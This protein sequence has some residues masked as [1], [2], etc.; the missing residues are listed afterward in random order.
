V[1][2]PPS[3]A[4]QRLDAAGRDKVAHAAAAIATS[5]LAEHP[6][7]VLRDALSELFDGGLGVAYT[8]HEGVVDR[9]V[10]PAHESVVRGIVHRHACWTWDAPDRMANRAVATG[11]LYGHD[12]ERIARFREALGKGIPGTAYQARVAVY[13]GARMTGW[14]GVLRGHHPGEFSRDDLLVLQALLPFMRPR[15]A[16]LR[17]FHRAP[18][19]DACVTAVLDALPQRAR[20]IDAAGRR[21]YANGLDAVAPDAPATHAIPLLL[22]DRPY[23]VD[24]RPAAPPLRDDGRLSPPVFAVA[25]RWVAG[26]PIPQICAEL[27][28]APSTVRTYVSRA[29]RHFGVRTRLALLRALCGSDGPVAH[30]PDPPQAQAT[31]PAPEPE[32]DFD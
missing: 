11:T 21:A 14:F 24:L 19:T 27:G 15:L 18:L 23:T 22:D 4:W 8:V 13:Q 10:G 5:G 7:H 17:M 3:A 12:P 6:W 30:T 20:L 2:V 16:V 9:A 32:P 28:F 1:G 29:Y 25:R 31:S 26:L